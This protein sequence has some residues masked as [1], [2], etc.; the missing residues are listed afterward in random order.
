MKF[1]VLARLFVDSNPG[2]SVDF[3]GNGQYH[4]FYGKGKAYT[5]RSTSHYALAERFGLIPEPEPITDRRCREIVKL[6][7]SGKKVLVTNYFNDT[8]R[9]LYLDTSCEGIDVVPCAE[10]DDYD[11]TIYQITL[12]TPDSDPVWWSKNVIA[13]MPAK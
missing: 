8:L 4:V 12:K 9:C 13:W 11:R 2:G 1:E 10:R 7:R 5:Y 3:L 6:L